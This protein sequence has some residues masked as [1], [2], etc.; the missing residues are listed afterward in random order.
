M[1]VSRR[2]LAKRVVV[3]ARRAETR[4]QCESQ[5]WCDAVF[6]DPVESVKGSDLVVVCAPVDVVAT[7]VGDIAPGLDSDVL[8]TDVGS[9]KSLICRSTK[10][11]LGGRGT[12]IGSHP[13]VGSEKGGMENA[14][15]E[16]FSGGACFVTPL[17]E[18][19][20]DKVELLARFWGNLGMQ[21]TTASPEKHDEIVAH[22]SHLPHVL[23][24]ALCV[25]LSRSEGWEAFSGAGLRDTTRIAGANAQLW[26]AIIKENREE[27]LRAIENFESELNS[28]KSYLRNEEWHRVTHFLERGKQFRDSLL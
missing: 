2:G 8:I 23:A 26:M 22:I 20:E 5:G 28:I 15:L 1:A 16:L 11:R 25:Q 3:W 13:M 6:A 27:V 19:P 18:C 17:E 4:L 10:G 21:V 14:T 9:T 12:F 7:M 24:S